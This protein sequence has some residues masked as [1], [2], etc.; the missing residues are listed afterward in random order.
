MLCWLLAENVSSLGTVEDMD[1]EWIRGKD[2][3]RKRTGKGFRPKTGRGRDRRREEEG[4][5]ESEER[6]D[7][8]AGGKANCDEI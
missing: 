4:V 7:I 3:E 1:G 6:E 2:S 5:G 8:G